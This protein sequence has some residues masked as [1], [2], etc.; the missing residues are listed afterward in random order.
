MVI[1]KLVGLYL[2]GSLA[3]LMVMSLFGRT[4]WQTVKNTVTCAAV[5]GLQLSFAAW[6]GALNKQSA[7]WLVVLGWAQWSQLD[8]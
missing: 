5:V 3:L 6:F 7:P 2:A 8:A 4:V 1:L